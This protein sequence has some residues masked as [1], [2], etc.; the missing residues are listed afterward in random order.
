MSGIP[1]DRGF[2]FPTKFISIFSIPRNPAV[3][4]IAY[5]LA[6]VL[7]AYRGFVLGSVKREFQARY[8]SSMLGAAWAIINPLAM[9]LIYTLIF[10]QVMQAKLPGVD[11]PFG[12]SIYLCS[13]LITWGL[14]VEIVGR[15]QSVFLEN[16]G[17]IK[18][19]NFPHSC[20]P[21]IVVLS[22]LINFSIIF[23]LFMVFLLMTGAFP[24]WPLAGLLPVLIVQLLLAVGLGVTAGI[25]NVFFRD[26]GQILGVV[27]QF[28]FWL[29]PIV[30]PA[31]IVPDWA[32]SIVIVLNPLAPIMD[33][34]QTIFVM[35]HWPDWIS[36]LP[37]L[38]VG[39]ALCLSG[40]HLFRR[41]A[42]EMVDEL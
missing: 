36:L 21:V 8:R 33:A 18:K 5:S 16:A 29:T 22:A 24:G 34:Y 30:Y 39:L 31:T 3:S 41:R 6:R 19:I 20:L 26:V 4:M 28:W 11:S 9:I 37:A 35:Q 25:L 23:A 10:S 12:Y 7:W 2:R 32:R 40:I 17:L 1:D 38:L 14:F 27:L 13:G 15:S 42:A